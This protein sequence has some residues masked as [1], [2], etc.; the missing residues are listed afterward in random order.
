MKKE[1]MDTLND[2]LLKAR[3]KINTHTSHTDIR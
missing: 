3:K 2:L 1:Q